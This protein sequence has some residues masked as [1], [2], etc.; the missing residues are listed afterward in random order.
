M[1][2]VDDIIDKFG[3]IRATARATG[4]ATSTV[5]G[6]KERGSIPDKQKPGILTAAKSQHVDI[7]PADFWPMEE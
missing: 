6:W 2:Y 7:S 3:G 1:S 4:K 5:Q